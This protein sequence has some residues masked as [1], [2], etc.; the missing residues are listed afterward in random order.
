MDRDTAVARI[1]QGLRFRSDQDSNIAMRLEEARRHFEMGKTLPWFLL[2]EDATLTLTAGTNSIALPTGFIRHAR[3]ERLRYSP[4]GYPSVVVPWKSLDDAEVAYGDSSAGGP[5]VAVLRSTTIRIFPTADVDYALTWSYYKNSTSLDGDNVD[6][7]AWLIHQP[8]VLIGEAGWR[9]AKD[10]GNE[11][12][13][14]QFDILR[15]KGQMSVLGEEIERELA[16]GPMQM[17]ANN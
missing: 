11:A 4:S 15:A 7:N 1:K 9:M 12:A 2:Q 8:D 13:A 5:L 6:D 17:G 16:G 14:A 3:F 10:L